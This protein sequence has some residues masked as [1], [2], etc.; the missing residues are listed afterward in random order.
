V[1][2]PLWKYNSP[3]NASRCSAPGQESGLNTAIVPPC[4][5][6]EVCPHILGVLVVRLG[7]DNDENDL[8]RS[9]RVSGLDRKN[10][11]S[12]EIGIDEFSRLKGIRKEKGTAAAKAGSTLKKVE[13]PAK[14]FNS[15]TECISARAMAVE[16][17]CTPNVLF[18]LPLSEMSR[19]IGN[20]RLNEHNFLAQSEKV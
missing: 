11:A 3:S 12:G 7:D 19:A 18:I 2:L 17:N 1:P 15:S 4:V 5:V 16:E 20:L 8:V 6:L 14:Y 10:L 9:C 13:C